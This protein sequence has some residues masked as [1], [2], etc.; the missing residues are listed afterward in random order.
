MSCPSRFATDLP[1][2]CLISLVQQA[3]EG[4]SVSL[5]KQAM[6]VGGCLLEK[7][8]PSDQP[9]TMTVYTTVDEAVEH[10]DTLLE[11]MA[12]SEHVVNTA[13]TQE[14]VAIAQDAVTKDWTVLIP[15]VLELIRLILENRKKKQ[16]APLGPS[17]NTQKVSGPHSKS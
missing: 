11:R 6:W 13:A 10:L 9:T 5:I 8:S 12:K 14:E 2:S 15:V 1:L 17:V 7:F 16:Q 3:K 4:V